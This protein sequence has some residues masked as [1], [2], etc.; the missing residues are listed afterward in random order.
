MLA[1]LVFSYS[2]ENLSNKKK[3]SFDPGAGLVFYAFALF[4]IIA[5]GLVCCLPP[6][7][8]EPIFMTPRGNSSDDDKSKGNDEDKKTLA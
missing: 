1:S 6:D 7:V 5:M 4:Y 8:E 3:G 2:V